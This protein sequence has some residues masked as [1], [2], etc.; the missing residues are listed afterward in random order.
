MK[1]QLLFEQKPILEHLRPYR[2][3]YYVLRDSQRCVCLIDP[4]VACIRKLKSR[5]FTIIPESI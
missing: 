5:G 4:S 1:Q 3:R 2:R